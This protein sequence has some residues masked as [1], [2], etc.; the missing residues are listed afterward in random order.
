MKLSYYGYRVRRRNTHKSLP[1]V[2]G[3]YV[4]T[5]I[6]LI[7]IFLYFNVDKIN[8]KR[9]KAHEAKADKSFQ[10]IIKYADIYTKDYNNNKISKKQ[11]I[12]NLAATSRDLES[13]HDSFRWRWGDQVTKELFLIKMELII[14]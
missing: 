4:L 8:Y 10:D 6:I 5:S 3:A 1:F 12:D 2:V 9:Y 7:I 13:L 14:D 11:M